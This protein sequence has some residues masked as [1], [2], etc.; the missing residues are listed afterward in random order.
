MR[1]AV[2]AVALAAALFGAAVPPASAAEN[3]DRA[4]ESLAQQIIDQR[5][6]DAAPMRVAVTAFL[7][8]DRRTTQ[9]TNF[10][11]TALTGEMVARSGGL[12]RVIERQQLEAALS[13]IEM[14]NVPIFEPDGAS[15][16]GRFLGVDALIIGN[17]TPLS[18]T[19]RL[20]ARLIKVDT[21]E[22]I[23]QARDWIPLTPTIASQLREEV[24]LSSVRIGG[25]QPDPRSGVWEGSGTCGDT[26]FGVALS[27]VVNPDNTVTAMQTYFPMGGQR[28][29]SGVLQME[30]TFDTA[31]SG[32]ALSPSDWLY[33][34]RGHTALGIEGR[35]DL[36]RGVFDGTYTVEGC[37][38]VELRRMN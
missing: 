14:Q 25:D 21:V 10:L 16:L 33:Q 5:P 11:M 35:M 4:V 13:E 7:A 18:D 23:A 8:S 31:T 17:I 6:A 22:T 9:F 20:N 1:Q 34:P 3:L 37:Q 38:A 36:D 24:R 29:E 30:G 32:L 27:I 12:F 2:R 26:Q 15:D 28:L 19:I